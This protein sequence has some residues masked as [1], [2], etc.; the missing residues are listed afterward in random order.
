MDP[1]LLLTRPEAQSRAFAEACRAAGFAGEVIVSPVLAIVP[2]AAQALPEEAVLVF[3]SA[4]G[5]AAAGAGLQGRRAWAVGGATAQAAR[6]AGMECRAAAGDA[7]AL[8]AAILADPPGAPLLHLRGAHARGRVAPRLAEAGLRAAERV[9]YDQQALPLSAAARAALAGARPVI[10]PLFS[11]RSARLVAAAAGP[12][13]APL[14]VLAFSG[15]VARAWDGPGR[16]EILSAPDAQ[17]M[18]EAVGRSAAP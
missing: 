4:N 14:H 15:A 2:R 8:V 3:T 16:V 17:A 11:P 7:D 9:V 10:L 12:A 13:A 6:A 18:A 5:V 1:I